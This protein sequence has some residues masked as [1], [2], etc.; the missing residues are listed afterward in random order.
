MAAPSLQHYSRDV[1][2][3]GVWDHQD[4]EHVTIVG[5]TGSGK[6]TLGY[7]L[8]DQAS[9][10]A[11]PSVSLMSKPKDKTTL[12]AQRLFALRRIRR[13]PA[14]YSPFAPSKPP[15]F[16]LRPDFTYDDD[17]DKPRHAEVFRS[18]LRSTY[19]QGDRIVYA[20]DLYGLL[21]RM[22][23]LQG[24][25]ETAWLN[26]RSGGGSLWVDTQKST[27][28][29]LLGFNQPTHL[30]LFRES[31]KRGRQRFNEIGGFDG[32]LVEDANMALGRH[33]CLYLN[34][35]DQTMCVVEG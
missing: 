25:F 16:V 19:K 4:G 24:E 20:P 13:W 26:W 32:R 35:N 14:P 8:L 5:R 1:F 11:K 7:Q 27:H 29:P 2:V 28:I 30:F 9:S 23:D 21:L 6:S 3:N 15:G 18:V 10:P 34:Q 22:P 33:E 12:E 31:D 17:V